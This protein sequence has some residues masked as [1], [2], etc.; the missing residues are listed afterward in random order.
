MGQTQKV[1]E[2]QYYRYKGNLYVYL[3]EVQSKHPVTREWGVSVLYA[4]EFG[5][6]YTLDIAEFYTEF[7]EEKFHQIKKLEEVQAVYVHGAKR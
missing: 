1:K 3:D 5:N 4:D 6:K 2:P 7:T